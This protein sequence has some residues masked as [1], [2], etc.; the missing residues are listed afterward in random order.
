MIAGSGGDKYVRS[1]HELAR[2]KSIGSRVTFTGRLDGADKW[3]AIRLSELFVLASHQENFGIAV[4]EALA[5]GV[6]VVISDQVNIWRE[7]LRSNAGFVC[8]P[9][10]D[11][12]T[13]ALAKWQ[14]LSQVERDNMSAAARACYVKYFG[15]EF[16]VERLRAEYASHLTPAN[17]N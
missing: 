6:P 14:S 4:V 12:V 16:P 7:I 15:L 13:A 3:A 8:T 11:S 17:V 10:R 2:A 9:E 5:C 1:L